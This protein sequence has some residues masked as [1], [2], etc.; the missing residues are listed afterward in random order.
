M[1]LRIGISSLPEK[2]RARDIRIRKE[3]SEV[4]KIQNYAARALVSLFLLYLG[5]FS[6]S[7]GGK[8]KTTES[9]TVKILNAA[10][11][12]KPD[13]F[14]EE[15]K[16][17][18]ASYPG[19]IAGASVE[20]VD[21][22]TNAISSAMKSDVLIFPSILNAQ[23]R[24]QAEAFYPLSATA[25]TLPQGLN[26]AYAAATPSTLWAVP[27]VLD[28]IVMVTKKSLEKSL[29]TQKVPSG[30]VDFYTAC[31]LSKN[32]FKVLP[33]YMIF[34]TGNPL[35]IMDSM[36][37]MQLAMGHEKY[38]IQSVKPEPGVTT[39]DVQAAVERGLRNLKR[40][41]NASS[42]AE[43]VELPQATDLNAF[44]KSSALL[45]VARYSEYLSLAKET[46]EQL[47][48]QPVYRSDKP[49]TVCYVIAAA[50]PVD[51]ANPARAKEFIERLVSQAPSLAGTHASLPAVFP[52][53]TEMEFSIY[54]RETHFFPRE[55]STALGQ[56]AVIDFM[57]NKFGLKELTDLWRLAFYI[58]AAQS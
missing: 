13:A 25:T 52:P 48:A 51:S 21:P 45:T 4:M 35:R 40:V 8:K 3:L 38:S 5:L 50:I 20:T 29:G 33:P 57:N 27:L 22:N 55:N 42:D 16:T 31:D 1:K 46:Q 34:L 56:K 17:F 12:I 6:V 19:L 11:E 10:G 26:T 30:W 23:L 9:L 41:W 32:W 24:N 54:P 7:C 28:P 18:A 2:I 58:P 37:A 43:M 44:L 47:V 39:E 36:A 53:N 15:L 49:V 14:K